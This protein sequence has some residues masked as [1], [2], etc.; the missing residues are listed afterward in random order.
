MNLSD[1]A[2]RADLSAYELSVREIASKDHIL[3]PSC[4]HNMQWSKEISEGNNLT[5]TYRTS[6]RIPNKELQSKTAFI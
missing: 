5:D 4:S 3:K 1:T 6:S 2:V